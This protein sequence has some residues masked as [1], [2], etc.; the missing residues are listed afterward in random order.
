MPRF[1][2]NYIKTT[3]FHVITQG[4]NKS[5]IFENTE[6]IILDD[7]KKD[8]IKLKELIIIL[9]TEYN[10]SLRKISEKLRIGRETVRKIYIE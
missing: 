6:D 10:I 9:K 7:L 2:R 4:I 1:P 5:Y 3:A 8:K